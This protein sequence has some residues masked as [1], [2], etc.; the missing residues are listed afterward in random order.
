MPSSTYA[1][2]VVNELSLLLTGGRLN[3]SSKSAIINAFNNES[4]S[5]DGL[6]LAQKLI[7]A[8]PEFHTSSAVFDATSTNRPEVSAPSPSNTRYKA[9]SS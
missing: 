2:T 6:K 3:T 4:N 9:V 8:T 5:A 1:N 7:A